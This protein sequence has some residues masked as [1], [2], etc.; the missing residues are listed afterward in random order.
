MASEINRWMF[1]TWSLTQLGLGVLLVA[2][3]WSLGN[4]PRVLAAAALAL[5]L[6]Q[7]FGLAG[8]TTELGRS[9][10]FVPRPLPPDLARRFGLLH[11]AY[12]LADFAK[13]GLLLALSALL[14]VVAFGLLVVLRLTLGRR[15]RDLAASGFRCMWRRAITAAD[16]ARIWSFREAALGLSMAMNHYTFKRPYPF[17]HSAC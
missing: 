15:E 13:A 9:I 7:A 16:Q 5:V 14:T 1:R 3:A 10:D 2:A 6:V 12:V 11:G 4:G 17:C 8:P